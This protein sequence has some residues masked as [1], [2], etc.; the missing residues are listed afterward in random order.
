MAYAD[1]LSK[2]TVQFFKAKKN[3]QEK[4]KKVI[5]FKEYDYVECLY[6]Y[7]ITKDNRFYHLP[8]IPH[9]HILLHP[10]IYTNYEIRL[11]ISE[12]HLGPELSCSDS[13]ELILESLIAFP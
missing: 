11:D 7:K 4:K 1:A 10:C 9:F 12:S 8:Y 2:Y 13:L 5:F 6:L 3:R